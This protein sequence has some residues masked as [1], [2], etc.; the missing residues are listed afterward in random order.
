MLKKIAPLAATAVL[1]LGGAGVAAAS[2]S[3]TV[4]AKPKLYGAC[5][6]TKTGAMRL[7]EPNRLKKSQHGKCK[8]SERK[9]YLPTRDGLPVVPPVPATVVFKRGTSVE[10]CTKT[11]DTVLTYDCKTPAPSPSPTTTAQ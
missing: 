6:S 2:E 3:A 8:S 10:T 1:L 4:A 9:I 5:I 7:L 11:T